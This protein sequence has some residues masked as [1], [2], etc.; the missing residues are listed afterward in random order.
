VF[1]LFKKVLLVTVTA[2]LSITPM[3]LSNLDNSVSSLPSYLEEQ[4]LSSSFFTQPEDLSAVSPESFLVLTDEDTLIHETDQLILYYNDKA[5]SV[6]VFNKSTGYIFS[7]HIE[8]PEA[9]SLNNFLASG[10]GFEFINIRRN[11]DL[12]QNVGVIDTIYQVETT[13]LSNGI[14][15][16]LEIGGF[17]A[18]RACE[19]LYP[20]Y[21]NG[22]YTEEEMVAIGFTNLDLAFD[23]EIRLLETGLEV[24][25]P[26][27]SIE[28]NNQDEVLLSSIILFPGLGATYMDEIPG[29]M[30]IPDGAGALIRYEDNQNAFLSPYIAPYYGIDLGIPSTRLNVSNYP[31]SLPIFGAVHGVNQ[32]AFLGNIL[33]GAENARLNV[34]PNGALNQPYN[35][36]FPKYNYRTI[37]RQAF[38]SD[39]SSGATRQ[40][41]TMIRDIQVAYTFLDSTDAH[42]VGLANAY[43]DTLELTKHSIS[44]VPLQLTY[45]MSDSKASFFGASL[46]EMSHANEVLAMH[47]AFLDAGIKAIDSVLLGWNDGGYSGMLPARYDLEN[48]LGRQREFETLFEALNESGS[49]ALINNYLFAGAS[50]DISFR[51]DIGSGVDQFRLEF[52]CRSCVHEKSGI[53]YTEK[54]FDLL[55]RD[56]TQLLNQSLTYLDESIGSHLVTMYDRGIITRAKMIEIVQEMLALGS[57]SLAYPIAPYVSYLDK[58]YQAPMF[59]SSL[60]YFDDLVPI[61]SIVYSEF[62]P[63]FSSYLNYNSEGK[64]RLL[65]LIDF[66][67]YPSY[68][69]SDQKASSLRD[70]DIN[71]YYTTEFNQWFDTIVNDSRWM[72][73]AL[74]SV[75]NERLLSREV[76]ALGLV[77]NTYENGVSIYINYQSTDQIVEDG[78][79][80]GFDILVIGGGE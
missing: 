48:R 15:L 41:Q 52:Q 6:K 62:M 58:I 14:K 51:R 34:F 63:V 61:Y 74:E 32:N 67:M 36:I 75:K 10:I 57:L 19:R 38:T 77:K 50:S 5:L 24:S 11:Y 18:T 22:D 16:S 71:Y 31:L 78:T 17:C 23:V 72:I 80:K 20:A 27:E 29:Y 47:Q 66:N 1:S 68:I 3:I 79:I 53:L 40:V 70:S 43:K 13:S 9:G 56:T 49:V 8:N 60:E 45:L 73:D 35:L 54:A 65:R 64:E 21:L 26:F 46:V 55:R 12:R 33:S 7:G 69:L 2:T 44:E 30:M 37:Y 25:V 39:K 42:Y 59:N 4:K 28:E 76:L